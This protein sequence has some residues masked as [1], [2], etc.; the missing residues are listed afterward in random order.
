MKCL[1]GHAYALDVVPVLARSLTKDHLVVKLRSKYSLAMTVEFLAAWFSSEVWLHLSL[2][3]KVEVQR[4]SLKSLESGS[5]F[6]WRLG[7]LGYLWESD[8]VSRF[9]R[10]FWWVYLNDDQVLS[11]SELSCCLLKALSQDS[12]IQFLSQAQEVPH[13]IFLMLRAAVTVFFVALTMFN[14]IFP[15]LVHHLDILRSSLIKRN[16]CTLHYCIWLRV[17]SDPVPHIK[18]CLVN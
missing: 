2:L 18:V 17:S 13:L 14:L 7:S 8:D 10:M 3:L 4:M 1:Q 5:G 11:F 16:G 6:G 9:S 15:I 12:H